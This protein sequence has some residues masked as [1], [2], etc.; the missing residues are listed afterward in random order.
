[1][2]RTAYIGLA[3]AGLFS[4]L[5]GTLLASHLIQLHH[6]VPTNKPNRSDHKGIVAFS[7]LIDVGFFIFLFG[8]LALFIHYFLELFRAFIA[9][10]VLL[11]EVVEGTVA[12]NGKLS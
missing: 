8:L 10:E 5:D 7:G 2:E 9:F 4:R 1:L 12:N 11:G 6:E 3:V